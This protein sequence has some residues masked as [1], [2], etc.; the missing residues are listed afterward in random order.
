MRTYLWTQLAIRQK[1]FVSDFG[2]F[3]NFDEISK[4]TPSQCVISRQK[5]K[6]EVLV[7]LNTVLEKRKVLLF[8]TSIS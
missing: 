2:R 5:P 4:L 6:T 7:V 1:T 8:I 3:G